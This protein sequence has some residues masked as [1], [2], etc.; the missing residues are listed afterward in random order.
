MHT[1][2]NASADIARASLVIISLTLADKVLAVIKE[3][4]VAHRFGISPDL[5]VFNIAYAFPGILLLILSG[6]LMQAFIPLYHEW[7]RELPSE[8]ADTRACALFWSA[9]LFFMLL[10]IAL[11]L[12]SPQVFTLIGYGFDEARQRQGVRL[13]QLLSVLLAVDGAG[14]VLAALLQAR[15]KFL[16][17]QTA[18]LFVNVVSI[19]VLLWFAV[20]LGIDALVW[21]LVAGTVCKT[22]YMVRA[23]GRGGFSFLA[24]FMPARS[25]V[26]VLVTLALP[27]LGSALLAN[28]NLLVDQ[29]MATGLSAG[30]VSSLRYAFRLYDMPVQIVI[31][32]FSKALFPFISQ[33]AAEMDYERMKKYFTQ[34]LIFICLL[35]VPATGGAVVLSRDMIAL[36]FQRGAFDAAAAEQTAQVLIFYSLGIFFSAYCFVNGVFFAAL[37]HTVPLFYMGLLST[38]LNIALNYVLMR[39]MGVQG[40]ALSTTVTGG[41]VVC[42][43]LC[44]L[45]RRLGITGLARVGGNACR[46]AAAGLVMLGAGWGVRSVLAA[47]EA[48]P[49]AIFCT[50]GSAMLAVYAAL[51]WLL[52]TPETAAYLSLAGRVFRAP[53]G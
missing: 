48:G 23:L 31:L 50:A 40:I 47:L 11:Y 20:R 16:H 21:G 26:A 25:E 19:A 29:V 12:L 42:V 8:Q 36:L 3:M 14:A 30:S 32:A 46:A 7:H 4:V 18:P 39:L 37:K 49:A 10:A 45:K 41:C 24:R 22:L 6:A 13:Q 28:C 51:L 17:L 52:R 44:V 43:F 53:R 9:A 35:S 38:G 2:D 34:S 33:Q 1:R 15:R 5:D 27:L